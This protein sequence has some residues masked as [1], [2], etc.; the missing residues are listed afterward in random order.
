MVNSESFL[1]TGKDVSGTVSPLDI[2]LF[3]Y[4]PH[5]S[6]QAELP[7][8]LEMLSFSIFGMSFL[9]SLI[10]NLLLS[11]GTVI[12]AYFLGRELLGEKSGLM[13]GLITAINPWSIFIGR[14]AYEPAAATFFFLLGLLVLLKYKKWQI[15]ISIPIFYAA[16]Y[17]YIGTKLIFIPFI[18]ICLLYTYF[19]VNKR[20]FIAQYSI[21]FLSAILLVGFFFFQI[22]SDPTS[23][24]LN[25]IFLPNNEFIP[26][27]VDILRKESIPSALTP[28][29]N[30]LTVYKDLVLVNTAN[31]LSPLYLFMTGDYFYSQ[32]RQGL[33]Y[34]IDALFLLL[35]I[36]GVYL[37]HKKVL[38]LFSSFFL[39]GLLPQILHGGKEFGNFTPHII[40]VI[41]TFIFLIGYGI[42]FF[43]EELKGRWKMIGGA[44]I[45]ALYAFSLINFLYI[46]L[47]VAPIQAGIF[48]FP[49]RVAARYI[50]ESSKMSKVTVLASDPAVAYRNYIFYSSSYTKGT[51]TEI[52]NA[53]SKRERDNYILPNVRFIS[54]TGVTVDPNDTVV[55]EGR[56]YLKGSGKS[57]IPDLANTVSS[58]TIYNDR[59][60][61]GIRKNLFQILS[62]NSLNVDGLSPQNFCKKLITE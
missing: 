34:M 20:Q 32:Q 10:P 54:C 50:K 49:E 33:F 27:H 21:V 35:G 11:I 57:R 46:Y 24:R 18:L 58:Y 31:T 55:Q 29:A 7:Y 13:I 44:V 38:V 62:M 6:M 36:I 4:P 25:E 42:V 37:K 16:F 61:R 41:S 43:I 22:T 3:K 8:F 59:L 12:V 56:C 30:K 39:I 48:N 47:T 5:E 52:N 1:T 40:L 23:S 17:S 15:L 60:C 14:T 45:V 53:L 2:L 28:L 19:F 9:S 26:Q 51:A